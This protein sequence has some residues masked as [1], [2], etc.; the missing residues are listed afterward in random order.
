M[1]MGA[2]IYYYH[3]L[4]NQPLFAGFG[5]LRLRTRATPDAAAEPG[6]NGPS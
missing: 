5:F 3:W 6:T 2:L 4:D 1:Y